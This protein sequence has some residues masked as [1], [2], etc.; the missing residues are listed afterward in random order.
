MPMKPIKR[1][2]KIW[3]LCCSITGYLLKFMVYEGKKES[4]EKGSLGEKT[5]LE[6]TSSYQ[7][8]GYYIFFDRFFSSIDLVSKL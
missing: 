3:A 8:K 1:G 4:N 5:V 6:M 2:F 7:E